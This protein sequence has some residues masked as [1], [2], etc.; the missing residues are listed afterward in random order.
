MTDAQP[1]RAVEWSPRAIRDLQ[2]IHAYIRQF[3]PQAADRFTARLI[4]AVESLAIQPD[5]GRQAGRFR[6]LLAVSPYIVRYRVI[7]NGI[8]VARIKH[9]AQR[10]D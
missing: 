2:G 9:A 5:R 10:P 7:R 4:A 1:P 3:A 6:E 8:E